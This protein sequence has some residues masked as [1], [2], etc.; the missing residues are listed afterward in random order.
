MPNPGYYAVDVRGRTTIPRE[1]L[2]LNV[3]PDPKTVLSGLLIVVEEPGLL[4]L[5]EREWIYDRVDV[6]TA[7]QGPLAPDS[8][9]YLYR[10]RSEHFARPA[11][12][13]DRMGVRR[14]YVTQIEE[15]LL[16]HG[17]DFR[18]GYERSSDAPPGHLVFDD[19]PPA[20]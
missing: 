8:H 2:Y 12:A 1:L 11:D 3:E 13:L 15:A 10:A 20:G 17:A 6:A 16:E 5:D 4:A 7:L 19:F 9:V 18:A 14:S